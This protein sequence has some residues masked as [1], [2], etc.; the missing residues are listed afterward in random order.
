[1]K[2]IAP[3]G[4]REPNMPQDIEEPPAMRAAECPFCERAVLVYEEPPRCPI[5]ACPLDDDRMTPYVWPGE[6]P[7][8]D[9]G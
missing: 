1:M 7:A 8:P 3:P 5:C 4:A 2:G 9:P 6:R